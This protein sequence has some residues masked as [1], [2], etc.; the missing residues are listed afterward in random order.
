M[1]LAGATKKNRK[2]NLGDST[3]YIIEGSPGAAHEFEDHSAIDMLGGEES[4]GDDIEAKM[5]GESS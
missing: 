2:N 4:V 5:R 1:S 3:E